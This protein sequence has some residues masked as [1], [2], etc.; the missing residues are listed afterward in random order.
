MQRSAP[1]KESAER[2]PRP[3]A[4]FP[5]LRPAPSSTRSLGV[6]ASRSR[7][8]PEPVEPT[9]SA[10]PHRRP[11]PAPARAIPTAAAFAPPGPFARP[12]RTF[13]AAKIDQ[14]GGYR[15]NFESA[16]NGVP[17]QGKLLMQD[18]D[19]AFRRRLPRQESHLGPAPRRTALHAT[20]LQC[21]PSHPTRRYL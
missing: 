21:L 6:R 8:D 10:P 9:E 18:Y 19:F 4:C 1:T 7:T 14:S 15:F 12:F 11:R 17:Y 16:K 13:S 3:V 20:H 2:P 5:A